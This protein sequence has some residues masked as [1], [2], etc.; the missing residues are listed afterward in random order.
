MTEQDASTLELIRAHADAVDALKDFADLYPEEGDYYA[1][2]QVL[3]YNLVYVAAELYPKF[4][5]LLS[6]I[7]DT[8]PVS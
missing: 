3:V 8:K 6:P 2:F 4:R 1:V 5:L 7:D